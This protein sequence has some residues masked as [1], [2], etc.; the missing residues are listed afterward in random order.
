MILLNLSKVYLFNRANILPGYRPDDFSTFDWTEWK[1]W[2]ELD[3]L[4][5]YGVGPDKTM[6]VGKSADNHIS[7]V[8]NLIQAAHDHNIGVH[9]YTF[10][11]D[12]LLFD[13]K[14]SA[15]NEYEQL[16]NLDVDEFFSDFP[17]TLVRYLEN[18]KC[19][20]HQSED[21]N[22]EDSARTL[23]LTLSLL[24]VILFYVQ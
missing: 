24:S 8:S 2:E 15:E 3:K 1:F 20:E 17:E 12:N 19:K 4:N 21:D 18:K 14:F 5:I 10:K 11:N 16:I 9:P 13:Y 6:I 22:S 7:Y 23:S